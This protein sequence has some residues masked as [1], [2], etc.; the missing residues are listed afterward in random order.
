MRELPVLFQTDMVQSILDGRKDMTRRTRGL[1]KVNKS[2]NEWEAK[3]MGGDLF[4]F[5]AKDGSRRIEVKSPYGN[6]GDVLWVREAFAYTQF[7]FDKSLITGRGEVGIPE[8]IIYR[9]DDT[10]KDWDGK[11]KPSIHMPKEAARIWLKVVSVKLER[12][13]DISEED[14]VREGIEYV[15]S[16]LCQGY[17][18]YEGTG[19]TIG[20]FKVST[21]VVD[22]PKQSFESLWISINGQESWDS[23]P[24]VWV[25]EYEI[26]STT[27]KPSE[28]IVNDIDFETE[29]G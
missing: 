2:P 9:A 19:T 4:C 15:V 18:D 17:K 11:W 10:D 22:N 25:I 21:S 3:H 16:E 27:G 14:A 28:C 23:N 8:S 6:P 20:G 7:M 1:S 26:L 29:N 13:H 24:W 5:F 12:A